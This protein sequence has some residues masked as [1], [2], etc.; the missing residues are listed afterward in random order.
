[1]KSEN[2]DEKYKNENFLKKQNFAAKNRRGGSSVSIFR[3]KM[4]LMG[5]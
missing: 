5:N 2:V 1:V 3:P 4:C